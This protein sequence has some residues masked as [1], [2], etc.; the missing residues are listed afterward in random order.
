MRE[1]V[2]CNIKN[3]QKAMQAV[4]YLTNRPKTE[5]PGFSLMYGYPGVGKTRLG[6]RLAYKHRM[7]YIRVRTVA[8]PKSF[9]LQLMKIINYRLPED[10]REKESRLNR[11]ATHELYQKTIDI[12]NIHPEIM[13]IIDEFDHAV[14]N[15]KLRET[16]RDIGEETIASIILFGMEKIY[17][18]LKKENPLFFDRCIINVK[19]C[20]PD[21]DDVGIVFK[22]VSDII[23][24]DD[25]IEETFN[26]IRHPNPDKPQYTER[27]NV[28]K[29]VKYIYMFEQFAAK[30]E[31]TELSLSD[32]EEGEK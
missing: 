23:I 26:K 12:L 13:I 3:V 10:E 7:I 32:F 19:F 4:S 30:R 28:R 16:I 25:L 14:K 5:L 22:E 21:L 29:V 1:N 9:L 6:E 8:T 15:Y 20:E 17:N 2:L 11:L 27:V 24:K 18:N 31:L